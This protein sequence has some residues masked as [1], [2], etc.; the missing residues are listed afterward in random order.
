MD[1][2]E[3]V[4]ITKTQW[5]LLNQVRGLEPDTYYMV[6]SAKAEGKGYVLEGKSDTLDRL[7]SDLYEECEL[8]PKSKQSTLRSLISRLE[9]EESDDF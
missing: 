7:R 8:A 4:S 9:P 2:V 6:I 1:E 5:H 3:T